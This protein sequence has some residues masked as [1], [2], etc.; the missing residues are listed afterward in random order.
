MSAILDFAV[1]FFIEM[2]FVGRQNDYSMS[3]RGIPCHL[4]TR[5][6]KFFIFYIS[7][8]AQWV[9]RGARSW[10]SELAMLE[11][12]GSSLIRDAD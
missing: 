1:C 3:K 7:S 4:P 11:G 6:M 10:P 8:V 12:E 2:R 5:T 9:R